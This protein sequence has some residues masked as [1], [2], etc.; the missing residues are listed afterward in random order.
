LQGIVAGSIVSVLVVGTI[1]VGGRFSPKYP[2]LPLKTDGCDD[3]GF[4]NATSAT[5]SIPVDNDLPAIFQLS[6]MYYSLLGIIIMLVVGY[7]VSIWTGGNESVDEILLTPLCRSKNYKEMQWK[8]DVQYNTIDQALTDLKK[9]V[10][11][12]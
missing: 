4:L 6:F 2:W 5:T 11:G 12:V 1:M 3:F 9:P 8:K 10:D 7:P